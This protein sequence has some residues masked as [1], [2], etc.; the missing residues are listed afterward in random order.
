[1]LIC[2]SLFGSLCLAIWNIPLGLKMFSFI[3]AGMNGGLNPMLFGLA[4]QLVSD[5]PTDPFSAY[6]YTNL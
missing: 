4:S 6:A 5:K 1:M 3:T 2:D